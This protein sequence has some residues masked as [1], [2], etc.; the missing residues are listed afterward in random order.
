[1]G[2]ATL[3][4]ALVSAMPAFGV[5]AQG[6]GTFRGAEQGAARGNA[7]A[8]PI[9]GIVGGAVGAGVGGVNGALGISLRYRRVHDARG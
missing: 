6:Q 2:K 9:D 4:L 3:V 8:R 5:A 1:M 7:V